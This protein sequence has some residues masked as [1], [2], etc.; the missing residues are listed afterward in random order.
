MSKF[1][2]AENDLV[3]KILILTKQNILKK[4]IKS[5]LEEKIEEIKNMS[6]F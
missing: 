6:I 5:V 3:F 4:N 1:Y 2:T